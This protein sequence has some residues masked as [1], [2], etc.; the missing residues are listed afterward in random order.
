VL[1][2]IC[3]SIPPG[4]SSLMI[5]RYIHMR[6]LL[7]CLPFLAR[8]VWT[9]P[10]TDPYMPACTHLHAHHT[11]PSIPSS[12]PPLSVDLLSEVPPA[13]S[14][15]WEKSESNVMDR[16]PRNRKVDRLVRPSLL[17]YCYAQAGLI[18]VCVC[19]CVCVCVRE[20][21]RVC[22][23]VC[24]CVCVYQTSGWLLMRVVHRPWKT[25]EDTPQNDPSPNSHHQPPL[26]NHPHPNRSLR[27]RN[28][29][30]NPKP[31]RH[32]PHL[33]S[34]P[35]CPHRTAPQPHPQP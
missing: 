26:P 9:L 3:F 19:A 2:N 35:P 34:L 4:M 23:C 1:I 11:P 15:A 5:L 33:L 7:L 12:T 22:V 28:P 8:L 20:C 6:M 10:L 13:I 32:Q 31:T 18:E 29:N 16:P 17:A 30:P 25:E 24:V 27:N 14:F 21:V